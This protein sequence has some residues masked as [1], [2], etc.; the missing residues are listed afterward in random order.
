M[1][2]NA[3]RW[4]DSIPSL[5]ALI[6]ELSHVDRIALDTEFHREKTYYPKLALL[7][8]AWEG[9]IALIDPLAVDIAP[10]AKILD[11][12]VLI[13]MHAAQQDLEVMER[14]CGVVP[15]R[16]FDTQIAAGFIGFSSPSLL[17]LA[18]S[19]LHVKLS[20]GDRLT[21]WLRRPLDD[22]QKSY[23]ASDV[24]HL[25]AMHDE[26]VSRLNSRGRLSW[27]LE[28]CDWMRTHFGGP[29][30]PADAWLRIK[31]ARQLRG[32]ARGVAQAIAAWRERSA[33]AKDLPVRFLLGDLAVVSISQRP[34][35]TTADLAAVRGVDERMAKG[36]LG[37][38]I[39]AAAQEGLH[40][41][42]V[43]ADVSPVESLDRELRPALTLVSAWV[44]QVA[45]DHQ[46]DP[47]LLATRQDLSD[48]LRGD[49]AAALSHGWRAEMVGD[50]IGR[51]VAGQ[52]SIAFD[53]HGELVLEPRFG[54]QPPEIV[55]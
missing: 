9:G 45:R 46:I 28:E 31:E 8:L 29:P 1:T 20:K 51:L 17:N 49:P 40:A 18:E 22:D 47:A 5:T 6:D 14:A 44:S 37:Q 2:E 13:V 7:Q 21:D 55:N 12:D 43:K 26:L 38:G 50:A 27:A 3:Y 33:A 24:E 23:A 39:V 10:F 4:I 30:D 53:G 52:A 15:R 11:S 48:L 25:C 32:K 36:P 19:L 42:P 16:L 35:A 54:S 41:A 34:P